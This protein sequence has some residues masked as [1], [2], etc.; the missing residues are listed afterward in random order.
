[1]FVLRG[2]AKVSVAAEERARGWL[3]DLGSLLSVGRQRA[4][5]F[6]SE[7]WS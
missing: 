2:C 7:E 1:M 3:A 5:C 6:L 4:T